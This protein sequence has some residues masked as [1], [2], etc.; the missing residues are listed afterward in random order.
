MSASYTN[1]LASLLRIKQRLSHLSLL[2]EHLGPSSPSPF[3]C[4]LSVL[5]QKITSEEYALHKQAAA[6]K[7]KLSPGSL[8][9]ANEVTSFFEIGKRM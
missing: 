6:L 2:K 9:E 8:L 4:P 7:E 1:T 5:V 3:A